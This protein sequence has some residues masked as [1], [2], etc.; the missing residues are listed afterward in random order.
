MSLVK[1]ASMSGGSTNANGNRVSFVGSA[2]ADGIPFRGPNV[3]LRPAELAASTSTVYD[4]HAR[5]FNMADPEQLQQ[6]E[7]VMDA[8][9]NGW[10]RVIT[11]DHHWV[12]L[13]DGTITVYVYCVW[14]E[15]YHELDRW[16]LA[17][18]LDGSAMPG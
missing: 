3:P 13:P 17:R 8:S 12:Q 18:I 16:R 2:A 14:T 11:A 9:A 10:F 6:F 15:S 1:Y 5:V 7:R 4:A